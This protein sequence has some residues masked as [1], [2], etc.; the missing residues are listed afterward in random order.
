MSN[1][2]YDSGAYIVVVL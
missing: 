1:L 2:R